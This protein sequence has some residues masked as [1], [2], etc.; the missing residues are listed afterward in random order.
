MVRE[1][2]AHGVSLRTTTHPPRDTI[3]SDSLTQEH[4]MPK[5]NLGEHYLS[6]MCKLL[7]I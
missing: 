3:S 1:V 4:N 5:A 6:P 7:Y 2:V